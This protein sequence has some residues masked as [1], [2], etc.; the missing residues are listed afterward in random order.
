MNYCDD[1][2]T[3]AETYVT[4]CVYPGAISTEEVSARLG[5]TPTRVQ[6]ATDRVA[7]AD[8]NVQ[9]ATPS[10]WFLSSK[11]HV[12][13]RDFRRHLDW[14]LDQLVARA[15]ELSSLRAAGTTLSVS[16]YWRSAFGHGG[17]EISPSQAGKLASLE[18]S[19]WFDFYCEGS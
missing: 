7:R 8:G 9:A 16:C 4:L 10:A 3:C 2:P 18:L 13:S 19:C 14:L 17:P 11:S 12:V 5:L 1:W 15:L 6:A